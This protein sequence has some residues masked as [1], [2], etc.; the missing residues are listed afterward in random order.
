[1][2]RTLLLLLLFVVLLVAWLAFGWS[3]RDPVE[4]PALPAAAAPTA[5]RAQGGEGRLVTL[6]SAATEI[7]LALGAGGRLVGC[8]SGARQLP[9]TEA[10]AD[11]GYLRTLPA[12]PLA[13]LEP[14]LVV[15]DAA[16]G[17][18]GTL[19]QWRSLGLE[20]VVLAP[21]QDV[22]GALRRV[23]T[24]AAALDV[25]ERGGRL[26]AAMQADIEAAAAQ[27]GPAS[28]PRVMVLYARSAKA[29]HVAG[30]GTPAD[31]LLQLAGVSNAVAVD[32]DLA[33]TA[34]AAL[35]AAPQVLLVPQESLGL[36]G[37]LEGLLKQPGLHDTPA[38]Q[39]RAVLVFP[40][41]ALFGFGPRLGATLMSLRAQ[42]AALAGDLP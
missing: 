23:E 3:R 20:V 35:L 12:E 6:G 28:T 26:V 17:P 14:A 7:A 27:P 36:L 37:G 31:A 8:D 39:A 11:L 25:P 32:G 16:A 33:L 10:C 24:I 42:L 9:G 30:R 2:S 18:P 1:M 13:A 19:A 22:T 5:P 40:Q 41:H 29:L 38:A 15:A 34:E 4:A 21:V